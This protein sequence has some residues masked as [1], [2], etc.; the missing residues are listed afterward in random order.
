MKLITLKWDNFVLYQ[1]LFIFWHSLLLARCNFV[2]LLK[3]MILLTLQNRHCFRNDLFVWCESIFTDQ[4]LHV[5]KEKISHKGSNLKNKIDEWAVQQWALN[6]LAMK[7][8]GEW[9][10]VLVWWKRIFLFQV[11]SLF[12]QFT[13][14]LIQ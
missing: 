2:Q 4:F 7:I 10:A 6:N 11:G 13:I 8:A 14:K 12:N 1:I 9:S 5:C 3:S